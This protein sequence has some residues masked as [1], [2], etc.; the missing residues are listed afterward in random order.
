MCD[1]LIIHPEQTPKEIMDALLAQRNIYRKYLAVSGKVYELEFTPEFKVFHK[2]LRLGR[3]KEQY[4][5]KKEYIRIRYMEKRKKDIIE[6][7]GEEALTDYKSHKRYLKKD[8]NLK[9]KSNYIAKL[10]RESAKPDEQ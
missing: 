8:A 2:Q 10:E 7:Y 6:Q 9:P 5:E 3:L 4:Q 1:K